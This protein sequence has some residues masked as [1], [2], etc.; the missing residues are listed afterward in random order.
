M[1]G[2]NFSSAQD[3][4]KCVAFKTKQLRVSRVH[5]L[6]QREQIYLLSWIII[7]VTRSKYI[8][9]TFGQVILIAIGQCMFHANT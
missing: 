2:K 4:T 6:S 8:D 9:T 7:Q 5:L 3:D 1:D